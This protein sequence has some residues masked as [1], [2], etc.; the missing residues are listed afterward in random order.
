MEGGEDRGARG[1][2][3][4]V[5][6]WAVI[7]VAVLAAAGGDRPHPDAERALGDAAA[8][9][10]APIDE[11]NTRL[12]L[13][14]QPFKLTKRQ[15]LID[16]LGVRSGSGCTPSTNTPR[17]AGV[18]ARS[19]DGKGEAPR[20]R[21]RSLIQRLRLFSGWGRGC[22][23]YLQMLYRG[24][25]GYRNDAAL[26][27]VDPEASV[28]FVINHRSHMGLRAV[29]YIAASGVGVEATPSANGRRVRGLRG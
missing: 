29:T 3:I 8:A 25:I 27:K 15:V 26:A 17:Q 6:L 21:D 7:I 1:S 11:L 10:T 14:I 28:I 19:R 16:R 23:R 13:R 5:P 24:R 18:P 9:P 4:A 20:R 12:K 22:P 2:Q